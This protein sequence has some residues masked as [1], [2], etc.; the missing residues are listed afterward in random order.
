MRE[1]ENG[2]RRAERKIDVRRQLGAAIMTRTP[3][4]AAQI[5]KNQ[6]RQ[7]G[8]GHGDTVDVEADPEMLA[9]TAEID[10][11]VSKSEKE[12]EA[13][14]VD[15]AMALMEQA[16]RTCRNYSVLLKLV[17]CTRQFCPR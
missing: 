4:P 1:L 10:E 13:G 2:V 11:K 9:L 5:A 3:V 8:E 16:E 14:N 7:R 12:G 6:L 17:L 15:E